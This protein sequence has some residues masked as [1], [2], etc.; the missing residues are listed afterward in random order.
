MHNKLLKRQISSYLKDG[1]LLENK[2]VRDL[3][4]AVKNAYNDYEESLNLNENALKKSEEEL[5]E[6]NN[7]LI[8]I[9]RNLEKTI[10][11][12]T[13]HLNDY[14]KKLTEKEKKI[15]S[16][17]NNISEIIIILDINFK[18]KYLSD[19]FYSLLGFSKKE[20]HFKKIIDFIDFKQFIELKKS[21]TQDLLKNKSF[22]VVIKNSKGKNIEFEAIV[23]T[24]VYDNKH[25]FIITLRNV[26]EIRKYQKEVLSQKMFYE[27]IIENI[28]ADIAIFDKDHRYL[29]LNKSAISNPELRKYII[30]KDDFEYAT[31]MG[32]DSNGPKKRRELFLKAK[33]TRKKV[34]WEDE[35]ID[36][37]G[38]SHVIF[39]TFY[40]LLDSLNKFN[41]MIG[42]GMDITEIKNAEKI[43]IKNEEKINLIMKSSLDGIIILNSKGVITFSNPAV[44]KMFGF[45][46]SELLNHSLK[47]NILKPS[48]IKDH[49][50][51][52]RNYF[53][54]GKDPRVNRLLET[55]VLNKDGKEI[56]IEVMALGI[57]TQN[58]YSLCVFMRDI[59]LRKEAEAKLEDI[60][61]YLEEK[62]KQRTAQLEFANKE[63][64]SFSYSVSHDL[65]SPLRA[66]D[67]WSL[68]LLEDYGEKLDSQAIEYIS[69]LR[70]EAVRMGELIDDLLKLSRI[71]KIELKSETINLTSL[72][73]EIFQRLIEFNN[74]KDIALDI[75]S[76]LILKGDKNM[77]EIMLNNLISNAIKFSGKKE[78][79]QI[80]I[81]K[82]NAE[83]KEIFY[84]KDNGAGFNFEYANKLF[85]AFQRMHRQSDFPGTGI[86]L[87]IVQR[88]VKLHG[89]EIWAESKINEGA[90]FNF[91]LNN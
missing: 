14:I 41:V 16:I 38:Q 83:E 62:V 78:S 30:G 12:K 85:G 39:R 82:L 61:K 29:F 73:N 54:S 35:I 53:A 80:K 15:N 70:N 22:D 31:Y 26:E 1:S 65:R 3:L 7:R 63:L 19:N 13:K 55:S 23:N 43:V 21:L 87:A 57:E 44:T 89:G 2:Q 25:N 50:N 34:Y 37:N 47:D 49:E 18:V 51:T 20:I 68:A 60:N 66:I 71:G 27:N 6:V 56:P 84:V 67:G 59:S 86:G 9:N 79:P 75:E 45:E 5:V 48:Q 36:S 42:F 24:Q 64:D 77:I 10:E 17:I 69:R 90:T 88:I 40:P 74:R 81:G 33:N 28:P 91:Y 52:I 11:L 76:D 32:R 4:D 72:S 46:E 8:F 58:E